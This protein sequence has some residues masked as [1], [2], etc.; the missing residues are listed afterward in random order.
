MHLMRRR[1]TLA[2]FAHRASCHPCLSLCCA[3][4]RCL[5]LPL[6]QGLVDFGLA[7]VWAEGFGSL[8]GLW[9]VFVLL[10]ARAL[11]LG[12]LGVAGWRVGAASLFLRLPT[13]SRLQAFLAARLLRKPKGH[14]EQHS[15]LPGAGVRRAANRRQ[16]RVV[17]LVNEAG[18]HARVA[19]GL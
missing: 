2:D 6:W 12:L 3:C 19:S 18:V 14:L 9:S 5:L 1:R 13:S 10:V 11:V 16:L 7:A 17:G 4:V 8:P 15:P